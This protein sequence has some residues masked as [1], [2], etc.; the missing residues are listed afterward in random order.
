VRM[1][2]FQISAEYPPA[3]A[4]TIIYN[5]TPKGSPAREL[6]TAMYAFAAG[7]SE[8]WKPKLDGLPHDS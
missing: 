2:Y 3:E 5:G 7:S 6:L 4:F 1:A 8:T